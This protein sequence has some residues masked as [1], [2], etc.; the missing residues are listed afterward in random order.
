MGRVTP[1]YLRHALLAF[2]EAVEAARV[3]S[4]ARNAGRTLSR[5][6]IEH[7]DWDTALYRECMELVEPTQVRSERGR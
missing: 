4:D 5:F 2:R 3:P 1:S 6:C 7:M